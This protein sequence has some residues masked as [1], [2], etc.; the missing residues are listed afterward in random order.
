MRIAS[1]EAFGLSSLVIQALEGRYGPE[2]LPVQERAVRELGLLEG[3]DGLIVAPTSAGKTLIAELALLRA[4]LQGGRALLALPTRALVEDKVADLED[5]YAHLGLRIIAGTRDRREHDWALG[6]RDYDVAVVVYEKLAS[7]LVSHPDYLDGVALVVLD[8]MQTLADPVRGWHGHWITHCLGEAK[9]ARGAPQALGLTADRRSAASLAKSLGCPLLVEEERP[10]PL[11]AGVLQGGVFHYQEWRN[12]PWSR[13]TWLHDGAPG[14]EWDEPDERRRNEL[15]ASAL[16][17]LERGSRVMCFVPSKRECQR[18]AREIAEELEA[19]APPVLERLR[20]LP[21]TVSAAHL[22]PV[23]ERRVAFHHGDLP[24]ELRA[25]VEEA[26]REGELRCLVATTTLAAGVN[27]PVDVALIDPRRWAPGA[28]GWVA[29]RVSGAEMEAMAGRAGR[30]L[31]GERPEVGRAA[32]VAAAPMES[33][34][35]IEIYFGDAPERD[36]LELG[37]EGLPLWLLRMAGRGESGPVPPA[38]VELCS[39]GT[40]WA[41]EELRE[42]ALIDE[43]GQATPRGRIAAAYG[44]SPE[45]MVGLEAWADAAPEEG[46]DEELLA[47]LCELPPAREAALPPPRRGGEGSP[48]ARELWRRL[49]DEEPPEDAALAEE[50]SAQRAVILLDWLSD[51]PTQEVERRHWV[52]AGAMGRLAQEVGR[53]AAAGARL[54]RAGAHPRANRVERLADALSLDVPL[55]AVGLGTLAPRGMPRDSLLALARE[56]APDPASVLEL[57]RERLEACVPPWLIDR[58]LARAARMSTERDREAQWRPAEESE[59]EAAAPEA[60]EGPRI[61]VRRRRPNEVAIG[62]RTVRLTKLQYELLL[63]LAQRPQECVSWDELYQAMWNEGLEPQPE[64]ISWHKRGLLK[65]IAKAA[66]RE[67]TEGLIQSV[68]GRGLM[69]DVEPEEVHVA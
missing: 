27:L 61:R 29:G 14:G 33:H 13:E 25:V 5:A 62:G 11:L 44:L 30:L 53:L 35:L 10:V 12:G 57:P 47:G 7:L 60:A 2:L 17:L 26:A 32:L 68:R 21:P 50:R 38:A 42:A 55:S 37:P 63:A 66:G 4:V 36:R 16:T 59:S 56:G 8:E 23:L 52:L 65:R 15:R 1:L 67:A 31:R 9:E 46:G 43:A 3:K 28:R 19:D 6:R 24:T 22:A 18:L 45:T 49:H 20:A 40:E 34:T 39:A 41:E 58:M 54:L 69:L 64:Q 48:Y 51:L